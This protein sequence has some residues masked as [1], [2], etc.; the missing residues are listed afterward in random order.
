[1]TWTAPRTWDNNKFVTADDL[2]EQLRD[3]FL[4]LL[5]RPSAVHTVDEVSNYSTTSTTWAD[6]DGTDLAHT[7]DVKSGAVEV[8][9]H[10]AVR[11][12]NSGANDTFVYFDVTVD[13]NRHAGDDG[14]VGESFDGGNAWSG[15]RTVSFTRRITGLTPGSH[16]FRLQWRVAS[17]AGTTTAT[18][19][20]GAGTTR[21][22]VHP[23]FWAK[24]AG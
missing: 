9:F 10:G 18:L 14:I 16:T 21:L 19:Y 17:S 24:D 12:S 13:G 15:M 1:M 22:D 8:H 2:N 20:A 3:N 6:V 23:Q 11:I 4:W 5:N 7:I